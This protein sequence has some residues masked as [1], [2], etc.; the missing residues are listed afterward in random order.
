MSL[1]AALRDA[2]AEDD[3][4]DE[5]D[6]DEEDDE[7]DEEEDEDAEEE[8]EEEDED[9]GEGGEEDQTA[10]PLPDVSNMSITQ[11]CLTLRTRLGLQGGIAETVESACKQLGVPREGSL[12]ADASRAVIAACTPKKAGAT[13]AKA[14]G[15]GA[16][17]AR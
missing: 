16:S 13:P 15:L 17:G 2:A 8:E 1:S 12:K 9:E 4:D 5:D 14:A 11:L 3:E 6:E 7:D 10:E